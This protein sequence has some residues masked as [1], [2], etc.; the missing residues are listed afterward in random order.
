MNSQITG[1]SVSNTQPTPPKKFEYLEKRMQAISLTDSDITISGRDDAGRKRKYKLLSASNEG[2]ILYHYFTIEGNPKTFLRNKKEISLKNERLHPSKVNE[3]GKC[4]FPA[5][6]SSDLFNTKTTI[7]PNKKYT[8]LYIVEGEL[9]AIAGSKYGLFISAIP[10]IHNIK[11]EDK[12]LHHDIYQLIEIGEV[13]NV[14]FLFDSD[15]HDIKYKDEETNVAAR[16]NSFFSAAWNFREKLKK[17]DVDVYIAHPKKENENSPK[18]LD[19]LLEANKGHEV[20][21][22]KDLDSFTD[23]EPIFFEVEPIT[24]K[25]KLKALFGLNDVNS[26]Y[27]RHKEALENKK[28]KFWHKS[29]QFDGEKL[30]TDYPFWI[31]NGMING[32]PNFSLESGLF[33]EWLGKELSLYKCKSF[34]VDE[35]F[36]QVKNN[37]ITEKTRSEIKT[38]TKEIIHKQDIKNAVSKN[39]RLFSREALEWLEYTEVK[40]LRD[41]KDAAF[42]YFKNCFV[43]ITAKGWEAQSYEE[44]KG[45]IWE[46]DIINYDFE[47]TK[48]TNFA[49]FDFNKFLLKITS[50]ETGEGW[51][52]DQKRYNSLLSSIGYLLHTYK[53]PTKAKAV[54]LVDEKSRPDEHNGR[55]GKSLIIKALNQ[56]RC[57]TIEDGKNYDQRNNRFVFQRVTPETKIYA[58]EDVKPQFLFEGFYN[59][60]TGQMSI[61]RKRLA[62]FV[63]PFEDSPKVAITT[64]YMPNSPRGAS[65]RARRVVIPLSS[66]FNDIHTPVDEFGKRFF[67]DWG[68]D[69]WNK[70]YCLMIESLRFFLAD[71][72]KTTEET[73]VMKEGKIL[74][75]TSPEFVEFMQGFWSEKIHASPESRN[76]NFLLFLEFSGMNVTKRTFRNWLKKW[77]DFKEVQYFDKAVDNRKDLLF[78]FEAG[79]NERK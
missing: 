52:A 78:W 46:K 2:G 77:A 7:N 79:K 19:D 73:D 4:K 29:Y 1:Q 22:I 35:I 26:F 15:L 71:G 48:N 8:N 53:D 57:T 49:D 13:K 34:G 33:V 66:Y 23:K 69:E 54:F 16:P 41:T 64:N 6:A 70:F 28:F 44:I 51:K 12:K 50:S 60:V 11:G 76:E 18:G 27:H 58:I 20:K 63:I 42:L 21:I 17:L 38:D 59:V 9:K 72:M 47:G 3:N 36:V 45:H 55:T 30:Q 67:N 37:V 32:K 56:L 14:I 40:P 39:H 68:K 43:K 5:G 62:P 10:G 25:A 31:Y 75:D 65:E 61:E 74:S 24:T